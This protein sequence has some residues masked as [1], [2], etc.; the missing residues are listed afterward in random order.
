FG[1]AKAREHEIGACGLHV[2]FAKFSDREGLSRLALFS[3]RIDPHCGAADD[4][5]RGSSRLIN[6]E[7]SV[8][9]DF[10]TSRAPPDAHLRNE[11]FFPR[12]IDAQAEASCPGAPDEVFRFSWR[13]GVDR[14]FGEIC[15]SVFSSPAEIPEAYRK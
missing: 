13:G 3:L 5:L 12:W 7:G 2:G 9:A 6:C 4:L 8:L 10:E 11:N 15:H 14:A 1:N